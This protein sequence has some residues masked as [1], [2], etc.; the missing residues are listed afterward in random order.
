MLGDATARVDGAAATTAAAG[1]GEGGGAAAAAALELEA[2]TRAH[3]YIKP[4]PQLSVPGNQLS[5][6]CER[7]ARKASS[8]AGWVID[9]NELARPADR[10]SD[11]DG[12]LARPEMGSQMKWPDPKKWAV[13]SDQTRDGQSPD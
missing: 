7:K 3:I 11:G 8:G 5:G 6:C 13:A 4:P 12:E 1:S 10:Q 9:R 2:C